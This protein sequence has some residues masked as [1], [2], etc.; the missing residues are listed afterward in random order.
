MNGSLFILTFAVG[1]AYGVAIAIGL[2]YLLAVVRVEM[3][4]SPGEA[5]PLLGRSD[6]RVDI[7]RTETRV[8][9]FGHIHRPISG[10]SRAMR[11]HLDR[12]PTT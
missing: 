2:R 6:V 7:D 1:L 10:A 5:L 8:S 9:I 4:K 12:G 3:A 11:L